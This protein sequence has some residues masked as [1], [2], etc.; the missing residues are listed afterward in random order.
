M[1]ELPLTLRLAPQP[2]RSATAWFLPGGDPGQWLELLARDFAESDVAIYVVPASR[3]D[4]RPA[5]I[6]VIPPAAKT[7]AQ[8]HP[9]PPWLPFGRLY[10]LYLPVD[11]QLWPPVTEEE[12]AARLRFPINFFH[13]AVGLIGFAP[14]DRVGIAQLLVTP[15]R[16]AMDWTLARPGNPPPAKLTSIMPLE[17]PD[18]GDI[19]ED[20]REDIGIERLSGAPPQPN[21]PKAHPLIKGAVKSPFAVLSNLL[22]RLAEKLRRKPGE[23]KP[24]SDKKAPGDAG[25]APGGKPAKAKPTPARTGPGIGERL[26]KLLS[27]G[28]EA[29]R[30]LTP[31]QFAALASALE[32]RRNREVNRLLSLLQSD[33][34]EGLRYA[35]PLA[36]DPGR[37]LAAPSASLGPRNINFSMSG[38]S[39]PADPWRLSEE[40]QQRLRENYRRLASRE[41]QLGRHRRAA[42]IFAQLLGDWT[43]AANAL[44]QGRHFREA[45]TLYRERLNNRLAAAE[46]LAEGGL[47][48]EAIPLY[49]ELAMF[50]RAGD[51]YT[52]LEQPEKAEAAYRKGVQQM[53]AAGDHLKAA[54]FLENRLKVPREALAVLD[55]AWPSRQNAVACKQEAFRL[56][57]RLD[58]V[59]EARSRVKTMGEYR[60]RQHAVR[61]ATILAGVATTFPDT[62]VQAA[63]ADA[64]KV[65]VG[66]NLDGASLGEASELLRYLPGLAPADALLPRDTQRF[67]RKVP[68]PPQA[69][70]MPMRPSL[71]HPVK[72]QRFNIVREFRLPPNI[73]WRAFTSHGP[74]FFGV[75]TQNEHW[76]ALRCNFHG[77][78][79]RLDL[80][81]V[82]SKTVGQVLSLLY[83]PKPATLGIIR[84]GARPIEHAVSFAGNDEGPEVRISMP[85][86]PQLPLA[87]ACDEFNNV[88]VLHNEAVTYLDLVLSV[89]DPAGEKLIATQVIGSDLIGSARPRG[90]F[91]LA[92][93]PNHIYVAL[94]TTLLIQ[95]YGRPWHVNPLPRR[96]THVTASHPQ[97]R[98]RLAVGMEEGIMVFTDGL[99]SRPAGEGLLSPRLAFT[100][101]GT[102]FA[103]AKSE[104][105]AYRFD[106]KQPQCIATFPG[107]AHDASSEALA[108]F[109]TEEMNELALITPAGAVQVIQINAG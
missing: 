66:R 32:E 20:A 93:R 4:R 56:L 33:P 90:I 79:Q 3:G 17:I 70:M 102:L 104:C 38:G 7:P 61:I 9:A 101:G 88:W 105:R 81:S 27:K 25:A 1:I 94:D 59:E 68:V 50:E 46:C 77:D 30:N 63:A 16:R 65:L 49:E 14:E 18:A 19:L 21:E 53:V 31:R 8:V 108:V 6:V 45:A 87:A 48:I 69:P 73:Q 28:A 72:P 58:D 39:G 52:Q 22:Q 13:P 64:T 92:V 10:S 98:N 2:L 29:L 15:V 24:P 67:L 82:Y 40:I 107:I 99:D 60:D 95:A 97:T 78:Y 47:L 34:D 86:L 12:L 41:L 85:W 91:N 100:R 37:G 75:G 11:A 83:C 106:G 35:L 71:R 57:A 5:G 84:M 44:K 54:A 89:F 51:L 80:G 43:S 76:F 96:V 62:E 55:S 103:A 26:S 23:E 42:Y 36:G 74:L 109:P